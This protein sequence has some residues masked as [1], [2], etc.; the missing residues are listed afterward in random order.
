MSFPFAEWTREVAV[1]LL[2]LLLPL[3][4]VPSYQ[5]LCFPWTW[6][7]QLTEASAA[8]GC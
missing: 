4:T 5:W 1:V 3:V 6:A 2:L 8:G 7:V